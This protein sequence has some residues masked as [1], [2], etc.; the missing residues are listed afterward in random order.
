MK[1]M[2]RIAEA[3][4]KAGANANMQNSKGRWEM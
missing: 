1:G 2:A 3:L 4:L